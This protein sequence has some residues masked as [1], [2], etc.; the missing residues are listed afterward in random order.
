MEIEIGLNPNCSEL[1]VYLDE[2]PIEEIRER[3]KRIGIR[4]ALVLSFWDME[5]VV[6]APEWDGEENKR[7]KVIFLDDLPKTVVKA[8]RTV[9]KGKTETKSY[10]K[11]EKVLEKHKIKSWEIQLTDEA[12][13]IDFSS[14]GLIRLVKEFAESHGPVVYAHQHC[15]VQLF[16]LLKQISEEFGKE[17]QGYDGG[18]VTEYEDW[19]E[20]QNPRSEN[21]N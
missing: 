1:V 12:K 16:P 3:L 10:K 13:K 8:L 4:E 17:V 7:E 21:E 19:L 15:Q 11:A 20:E 5:E 14:F 9:E 18:S 2:Y 6:E